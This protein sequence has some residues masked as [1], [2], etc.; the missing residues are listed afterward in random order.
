MFGLYFLNC[1]RK[2]NHM[3]NLLYTD[4]D[5]TFDKITRVDEAI[6]EIALKELNLNIYP[7]QLEIIGSD[8][9][10][11]AYASIGLPILY[12]HWSFGKSFMQQEYSYR[13]GLSGLAYEMVINSNPCIS[14]LMEENSMTMQTLVI[15]HAA[16]G[17]N[18]F[19][20]NN[21][22]FKEWTS[23][24]GIIDYLIFAKNYIQKC[25]EEHGPYKVEELL[26]ALHSIQDYG[27]DRYRRPEPLNKIKEKERQKERAKYVQEQANVLWSTIPKSAEA[28]ALLAATII[29]VNKRFPKDPEENILYFLEKHSPI[30]KDW[31]REIVRIV[32]K[33][34]QYF[35]PQRQTKLMNEGF[36]SFTHHYIMNRLWDKG[37]ISDGNMLEFISSHAGVLNQRNYN[38]KFYNGYNP[39]AL[40]FEMFTEIRRVCE[41]P[42]DEDKDYFPH[43]AGENWKEVILDAVDNFKD[44]SFVLQFLTPKTVRKWK[45]FEITNNYDDE[46]VTVTGIQNKSHFQ[47]IRNTLSKQYSIQCTQPT[48]E[49]TNANLKTTRELELRYT[50]FMNSSLN[51]DLS[52]VLTYIKSLWGYTVSLETAPLP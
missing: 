41:K 49:I 9:M 11:D 5:W 28:K 44:E 7:N 13:K 37:M 39:Y 4:N 33:L 15:A 23:A 24:D 50:P 25:E 6:S 18:H 20:K 36:A 14:Y 17:H 26:N 35:H 3:S 1:F 31:E 32:R 51:N 2:I 48:I 19:F 34:A 21:Y 45:M 29:D 43:I 47:Q 8:Q 46:F 30:L 12:S 16:Y 38:S 40:G 52:D 42:T 10:L 27:I 22:L